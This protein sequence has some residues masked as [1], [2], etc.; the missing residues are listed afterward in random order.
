MVGIKNDY[1]LK[2]GEREDP[3]VW[4]DFSHIDE[5]ITGNLPSSENIAEVFGKS[6]LKSW[7]HL[8][9]GVHWLSTKKGTTMHT[10]PRY[11]RYTHHLMVRNDG[12]RLHGMKDEEESHPILEPGAMYCLD[13]HSP[14]K[15][16]IDTRYG[17]DKPQYKIQIAI[18]ADE[19]LTPDETWV[20]VKK[21]LEEKSVSE[22]YIKYSGAAPNQPKPTQKAK[23]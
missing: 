15:V 17:V 3:L 8:E 10:D 16:S 6:R 11:P 22:S 1:I 14:H 12:F 9:N 21:L 5:V 23:L 19:I 7:G 13:A 20:I 18:D 4:V 2:E